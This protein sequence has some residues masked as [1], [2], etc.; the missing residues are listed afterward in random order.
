M[1]VPQSENSSPPSSAQSRRFKTWITIGATLLVILLGSAAFWFFGKQ[2]TR[3]APDP[4]SEWVRLAQEAAAKDP[5]A[6]LLLAVEAV[7]R[8]TPGSPAAVQALYDLLQG[9]DGHVLA[10]EGKAEI[11]ALSPDGHWLVV[12]DNTA[13]IV[14]LWDLPA[15]TAGADDASAVNHSAVK[16]LTL[17]PF[18]KGISAAAFNASGQFLAACDS[19]EAI[20]IWDVSAADPAAHISSVSGHKHTVHILAFS[21][22][23][24]WLVAG[25]KN[26]VYVWDLQAV[27]PSANYQMLLDRRSNVG[28]L[29]FSSDGRWL[30][31]NDADMAV[32]LWD[33]TAPDPLVTPLLLSGHKRNV[34]VLAFSSDGHWLATGS[35]DRTIRL[36]DM[37]KAPDMT[38]SV[39]VLSGHQAGVTA[40]AF[41]PDGRWLASGSDDGTVRLWD[42]HA[43]NPARHPFVMGGEK[44]NLH[45][46]VFSPDGRWLVV[47]GSP[48]LQLWDLAA[49]DPSARPVELN[50]PKGSAQKKLFTPDGR[51]LVTSGEGKVRL[52]Q[53]N[54][55]GLVDLACRTAGRNLSMTEWERYFPGQAY[56]ATCAP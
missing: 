29:A 19:I 15:L 52:W 6:G 12:S 36:W 55:T 30:A 31:N 51:W 17:G 38:T 44:V 16:S 8:T 33:M 40:L 13:K 39:F 22:D 1:S 35:Y 9:A 21:P 48:H 37:T 27:D 25:A 14:Y 2:D 4:A 53:V 49:A 3:A 54:V 7:K 42:M 26:N 41:S 10:T 23:M 34:N 56:G 28:S 46:P 50:S 24:H 32:M 45:S 18:L 43:A 20:W 47:N 11:H 5:A